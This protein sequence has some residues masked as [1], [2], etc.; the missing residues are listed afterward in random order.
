[1]DLETAISIIDRAFID[2]EQ[3][4][5]SNVERYVFI[6]SWHQKTYEKMADES[7]YSYTYT[8]LKQDVGPKLWTKISQALKKLDPSFKM[9]V[10]KSVM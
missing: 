4:T 1:M 9:K 7:N 8:Y 5:L 10:S 3:P 2:T 6:N